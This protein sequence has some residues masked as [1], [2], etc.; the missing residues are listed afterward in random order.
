MYVFFLLVLLGVCWG[1]SFT[2]ARYA[3]THGL[4]PLLYAFFHILG[5]F[6]LLIVINICK[7]K[8]ENIKKNTYGRSA[9]FG[10]N[11]IRKYTKFFLVTAFIGMLLPDLNKF[12]LAQH[13]ASGSLG[14][15]TNTVPLFIYPLALIMREETFSWWRFLGV[16]IGVLGVLLLMGNGSHLFAKINPWLFLALLS[17]LSY[18]L[19]SVYIVRNNPCELSSIELCLGMLFYATLLL[20][21]LAIMTLPHQLSIVFT[22]HLGL[23]VILE[24]LLTTFGYILLFVVLRKFG[25]VCYS[26]TDGI[27]AVTSLCFGIMF[28]A[29]RF[30]QWAFLGVLLILVGIAFILKKQ[31]QR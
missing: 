15:I 23:V 1:A 17:P 28:F 6:V 26:L 11:V 18:A 21:P 19:A 9:I 25:S 27:V 22:W 7:S 5:P 13:V 4:S 10:Y 8:V 30:N 24:I 12:F 31:W 3:T 14:V 20:L 16:I 2:L 29:E